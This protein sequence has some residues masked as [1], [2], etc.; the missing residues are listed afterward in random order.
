MS[1]SLKKELP[2]FYCRIIWC[3]E[4]SLGAKEVSE[5]IV[6]ACRNA[7]EEIRRRNE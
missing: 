5:N 4:T 2:I 6:G 1:T 3:K 7:L